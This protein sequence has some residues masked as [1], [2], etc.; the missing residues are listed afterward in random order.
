MV[1]FSSSLRFGF[2][3]DDHWTVEQNR[4]L[5]EPLA[6]VLSTLLDGTAN[7]RGVP[8]ATRPAMVASLWLDRHLFGVRPFGHH[9]HSLFLY[10]AA[11]AAAVFA[12]FSILRDRYAALVSGWFFALAP[13]HAEVACAVNYRE[14]LISA[15]GILLPLGWLFRPVRSKD[16]VASGLLIAGV[17][18]WGLCGKESAVFLGP[19]VLLVA[20]L[21]GIDDEW[22]EAR[23]RTLWF[24]GAA[25]LLWL[26]WRLALA[27][28]D[29]GIPR[30]PATGAWTRVCDTARYVVRCAAAAFV[31]VRPSPEYDNFG[32]ARAFWLAGLFALAGAFVVA[33]RRER[34]R[35]LALALG[36]AVVAPLGASPLFR[37]INPWADRYVFVSVLGGALAAGCLASRYA[38]SVSERLRTAFTWSAALG[39]GILC[40]ASA[41]VWADDRSLWTYSVT[42]APNSARA[43][44][45]LSRVERLSGNLDAAD[46]LVEHAL[47]IKP[48]HVPSHVTRVYNLLARGDVAAAREEIARVEQLGGATHP[49]IRRAR[50]CA[51]GGAE[52]AKRCVRGGG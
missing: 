3:Y 21:R 18:L 31:P 40:T 4:W 52:E 25:A 13:V 11:C 22:V 36:F 12:S 35:S 30:A 45:A 47:S 23:E 37:P 10:G 27:V 42:R 28:G 51:A 14:D 24:I 8:D 34:T 38:P 43:W 50:A 44:A 16:S 26:N 20:M 15:L 41:R 33:A 6:A 5:E 49:G 1:A 29:D 7:A 19:L 17:S 9:L 39:A 46:R 48:S 32:G 2:V